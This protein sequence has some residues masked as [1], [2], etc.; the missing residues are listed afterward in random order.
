MEKN[1]HLQS[2]IDQ[3]S[4][5]LMHTVCGGSY[6]KRDTQALMCGINTNRSSGT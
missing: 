4:V 1:A 2:G 5:K 6:G 3:G